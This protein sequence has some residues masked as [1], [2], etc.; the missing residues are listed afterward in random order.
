MLS[1]TEVIN[2]ALRIISANLI[3]D[4][5]E[6]SES[7][8]QAKGVYDQTVRVELETYAWGFAKQQ[9]ALAASATPPLFKFANSYP[10][11]SD[12]LRLVELDDRWVFSI[13][14]GVDT[15]PTPAY[16]IIGRSVNTDIGAPLK[17]TY[18]RD[19]T[20]DP[21]YWPATFTAVVSAAL[22]LALAM[23]LTKSEGM[24]SLA[25]KL[26]RRALNRARTS[27][28]IQMPPQNLPD[29]SWVTARLY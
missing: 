18:L 19:L 25:E 26:H 22:A 11:P 24:V 6:A 7:A 1:R 29:G 20:Q 4:P 10:L 2:D 17:I 12:F 14:R 28:A 5:D 15:E 23:P 9:A 27:N 21:T 3:A 13:V 8:R 16:E